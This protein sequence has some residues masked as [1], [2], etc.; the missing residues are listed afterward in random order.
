VH[1]LFVPLFPNGGF[2]YA[3]E[4]CSEYWEER[5][6]ERLLEIANL[7]PPPGKEAAWAKLQ[8]KKAKLV[9]E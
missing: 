4:S 7:P 8:E 3:A 1:G 5:N 6:R 9:L 2:Q